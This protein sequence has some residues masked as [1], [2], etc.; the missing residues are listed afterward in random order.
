MSTSI[1]TAPV[2]SGREEERTDKLPVS[3]KLAYGFGGV[4]VM[5]GHWLYNALARPVFNMHLGLSPTLIGTVLM[6]GRLTEAIVDVFFGWKSD[7]TRTRWGRRR[8]FILA[9]SIIGGLGLPCLFLASGR[10]DV[11]APWHQNAMFWFMLGSV[12]IFAPLFGMLLMQYA[13]LGNELH[14][15]TMNER[16]SWRSRPSCRKRRASRLPE[17]G[18]STPPDIRGSWC[19]THL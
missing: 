12:V 3:S 8:P 9:G 2:A 5:F 4:N 11:L 19:S 17:R 10:R 18:G 15:T 16:Q 6:F 14:P 7:N 13:C 1:Q